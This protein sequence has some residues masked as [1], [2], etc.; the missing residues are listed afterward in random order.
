MRHRSLAA[1]MHDRHP[2]TVDGVAAERPVNRAGR[3]PRHAPDDRLV[4]PLDRVDAELAG[5]A[6]MGPVVLGDHHHATD[7][8]VEPVHDPRPQHPADPGQAAAAMGEQRIDQRAVGMAGRGMHDDPGRLDDH[9]QVLVL[10]QH[11]ELARL[12][13]GVGGARRGDVEHD[14]VA[15]F[16]PVARLVYHPPAQRQA[17]LAHQRLQARARHLRQ[18]QGEEPVEPQ[19]LVRRLGDQLDRAP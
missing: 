13:D 8:A 14:R 9:D 2:L 12:G 18:P 19:A 11:L 1:P 4:D 10:E 3:R 15:R 17:A 6:D 5:E 7:L 16:D